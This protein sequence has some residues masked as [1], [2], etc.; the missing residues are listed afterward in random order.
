MKKVV[1]IVVAVLL[2]LGVLTM[3]LLW[4]LGGSEAST[5]LAIK[6]IERPDSDED[7]LADW[8]EALWH[9]DAANPDTD[10]DGSKDGEEIVLGR[11]PRRGGT[12]DRLLDP[13]ERLEALVRNAIETQDQPLGAPAGPLPALLVYT[14][15]DLTLEGDET[16]AS[17][18]RYARG[19]EAVLKRFTAAAPGTEAALLLK[20]LET[21]DEAA[22]APLAPAG[23]NYFTLVQDLIALRV[24]AS[25]ANQHLEL[26]NRAA[27]LTQLVFLMAEV[28]NQPLIAT[29]A[30]EEAPIKLMN[31][32]D[33]VKQFDAYFIAR[34]IK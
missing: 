31:F 32:L 11:D 13:Q 15:N 1:I 7:G 6:K 12:G 26:L 9:T 2:A 18:E 14:K 8:E 33:F 25:A 16:A 27:Y 20:Y 17:L 24:P 23:R 4:W 3:G 10:G 29:R 30:A 28:K 19:L 5:E 22:L 21:G 34:G